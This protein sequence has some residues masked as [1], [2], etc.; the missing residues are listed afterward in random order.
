MQLVASDFLTALPPSCLLAYV[1][2]AAAY[3]T[4][5]SNLN[6][7]LTAVGLQW[8]VSDFLRTEYR[9]EREGEEGVEGDGYDSPEE[10]EEVAVA[11]V[12]TDELLLLPPEARATAEAEAMAVEEEGLGSALAS[13]PRYGALDV[14]AGVPSQRLW[15]SIARQLRR[16]SADSRSEVRTCAMH[17]LTSMLT[18]HGASLSC[19][20]WDFLLHHILLPLL[21]ELTVKAEGASTDEPVAKQLGR[22][23][24]QAVLMLVHHSR[25]TAAKQWD[26]TWVLALNNAVRLFRTFLPLLQTRPTFPAAWERLLDFCERSL[27]SLPRSSEVALAAVGALIELMLSTV[28]GRRRVAVTPDRPGRTDSPPPPPPSLLS[29]Q[30]PSAGGVVPGR[31]DPTVERERLPLALWTSVWALIERS[32]D[33]ATVD[34]ESHGVHKA[35]LKARASGAPRGP[36]PRP[37]FL[38]TRVPFP[39]LLPPSSLVPTTVPHTA[40]NAHSSPSLAAARGPLH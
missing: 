13:A 34:A 4:Q 26:E 37:P 9:G 17:S 35:M 18:S 12:A 31:A 11:D 30:T 24:G 1:E 7:S 2:V 5:S 36:T 33:D 6:V 23:K 22:E 15:C 32:V 14:T 28:T 20:S 21:R 10:T 3:A 40:P 8:T 38:S 16:L 27:M 39:F 29:A 25:D 19:S